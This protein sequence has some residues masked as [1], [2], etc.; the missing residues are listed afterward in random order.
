MVS[1]RFQISEDITGE[2][3]I[4]MI[5]LTLYILVGRCMK[6]INPLISIAMV[7]MELTLSPET[8]TKKNL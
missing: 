7:S 6:G 5:S 1:A 3:R 2:A 8:T 4:V